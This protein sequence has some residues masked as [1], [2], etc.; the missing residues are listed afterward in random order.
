[1]ISV[2]VS[3]FEDDR[4]PTHHGSLV[5]DFFSSGQC[6]ACGLLRIH[7]RDRHLAV[8]LTVPLIGPVGDFQ[9]NVIHLHFIDGLFFLSNLKLFYN[10]GVVNSLFFLSI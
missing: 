3:G 8:H 6:V 10:L 7:P 5:C 4:L 1:M 2:Q 9:T